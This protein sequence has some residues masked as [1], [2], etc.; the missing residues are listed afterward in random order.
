MCVEKIDGNSSFF[1]FK[2][3]LRKVKRRRKAPYE[4]LGCKTEPEYKHPKNSFESNNNGLENDH[5]RC[6]N[7]VNTHCWDKQ[8]ALSFLI[9]FIY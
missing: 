8:Y 1:L 3:I 4:K 9:F 5:P 6:G 2:S 7:I